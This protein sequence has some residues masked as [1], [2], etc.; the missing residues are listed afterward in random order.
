MLGRRD[1]KDLY[2][3]QNPDI[4]PMEFKNAGN[5]KGLTEEKRV[6]YSPA[7]A[8]GNPQAFLKTAVDEIR[9]EGFGTSSVMTEKAS[10]GFGEWKDGQW[11]V[12]VV[13]DMKREGASTLTEDEKTFAAFAVWQ[14]GASEVGSRKSVTMGWIPVTLT[15]GSR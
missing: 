15:G 7:K 14:G 8:I 13:R 3:N 9:A 11:T 6:I 2:P 1:M 4:Y 12:Y 5:L 10:Y